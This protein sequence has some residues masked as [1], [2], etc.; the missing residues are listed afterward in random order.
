M[1]VN[2]DEVEGENDLIDDSFNVRFDL[3]FDNAF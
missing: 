3:I 2:D 1:N